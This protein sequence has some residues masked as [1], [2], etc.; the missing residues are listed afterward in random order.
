MEPRGDQHPGVRA[1]RDDSIDLA[2]LLQIVRA[3]RSWIVVPILRCIA[4]LTNVTKASPATNA[5][6]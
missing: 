4:G 2:R 1:S 3:R 5:A 6:S